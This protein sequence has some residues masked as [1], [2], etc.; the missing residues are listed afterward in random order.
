MIRCDCT[1]C[2]TAKGM[3]RRQHGF[4]LIELMVAMLLGL[5]VIAGVSSIFLANLRS[6]KTTTA[7]GNV[8]TNA[9]IAFELMA[10]DVRQAALTGCNSRGRIANVLSNGP[11]NG[12]T[13]WWADWSKAVYGYDDATTDPALSSLTSDKPVA[14]MDSLHLMGAVNLGV[15][16]MPSPGNNPANIKITKP[17]QDLKDG[18]IVMVCDPDHTTIFQ[19]TDYKS[20][21]V[22]VVHNSGN[23]SGNPGN[24]SKGLGFPTK[25]SG[26]ANGNAYTFGRSASMFKMA[27]HDWYIGTNSDGSTSL[28]R[29]AL[30]NR[31]SIAATVPQEMV[32]G[33]TGMQI[34]YHVNG[35]SD[36]KTATDVTIAGNW[37]DVDAVRIT[38]TLESKNKRAGTNGK[39]S[40]PVIRTFTSTTTI[41]NRVY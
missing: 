38:L 15:S 34:I 31:S 3:Y 17:S 26:N 20:S 28:F 19:V 7:L 21:N 41:R 10:R 40:K 11:N 23:G 12:G 32:R 29:V 2:G 16:V 18:D 9:R 13:A 35:N 5:I 1:S 36:Y 24:C 25:C 33:V 30:V 39:G 4:T 22:T 6:Y 27:A 8:Q 14:G 37:Q